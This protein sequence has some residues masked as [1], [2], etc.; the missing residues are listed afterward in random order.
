MKKYFV[1]V[2][3]EFLDEKLVDNFG[4]PEEKDYCE[5]GHARVTMKLLQPSPTDQR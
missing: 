2:D 4:L 3:G 1:L 5:L